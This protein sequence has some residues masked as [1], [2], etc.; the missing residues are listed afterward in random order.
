MENGQ[1]VTFLHAPLSHFAID[2]LT[3]KGPR[4][5]ADVGRP[6]DATRKLAQVGAVRTGSW[7]CAAGGWPSLSQRATTEIFLVLSGHGCLTDLDGQ[8]H[9]FGPGDTVVL[10]KGWSG[11][12]DVLQDIHKV[13]V[14]HDHANIEETSNPIRARVAHYN[15]CAPQY[16]SSLTA[17]TDAIH[18]SPH[19]GADTIYTM[20]PTEVG[21]WMCTPGSF[22]VIDCDSTECFHVLEGVFFLTNADGTAMRCVAGDTVML[23]KG[24]TGHWDIIETVKKLWVIVE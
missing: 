10:P 9:Y 4:K 3:P 1:V 22:P 18:G 8:Q 23:P 20:G 11:R 7:W 21:Y 17:R 24:W 15:Q 5:N 13:W 6:H 14:V 2:K 19:S 16:L 12:W